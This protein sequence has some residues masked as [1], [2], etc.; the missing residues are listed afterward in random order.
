MLGIAETPSARLEDLVLAVRPLV[1]VL[2][3]CEKPGNLG[4]VLRTADGAGL[5]AV[6]VADTR[7][8]RSQPRARRK[9][10]LDSGA[11]HHPEHFR[12]RDHLSG[13]HDARDYSL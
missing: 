13:A 6:I 11:A 4:A 2:E 12:R 7:I 5:A 1:A 3:S 8:C 9:T 10:A